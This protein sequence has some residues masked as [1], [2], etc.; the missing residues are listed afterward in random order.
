MIYTYSIIA[1]LFLGLSILNL[2]ITASKYITSIL[3]LMAI[4]FG[5]ASNRIDW[6]G[7]AQIVAFGWLVYLSYKKTLSKNIRIVVVVC[8]FIAG[9]RLFFHRLPGF[10]NWALLSNFRFSQDSTPY[11]LYLNFDSTVVGFFILFFGFKLVDFRKGLLIK[12]LKISLPSIVIGLIVILI[13]ALSTGYV[14]FDPKLPAV[15]LIWV[16]NMIFFVCVIEESIFR[17]VIQQNLNQR[18]KLY[19]YGKYIALICASLL[20]GLAHYQGGVAYILLASV[21]GLFFGYVY[22]RTNRIESSIF[23]H[24]ILNFSHFIFFSYPALIP[25]N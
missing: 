22:M 21:A 19:K 3:F 9:F 14:R 8:A 6:I 1:Y 11:S 5:L 25:M 15:T 16:I 13:L 2:W 12:T 7:L 24:F 23:F 18:F 17:G 4:I 20:F 10:N